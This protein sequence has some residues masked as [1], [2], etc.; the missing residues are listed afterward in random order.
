MLA[1]FPAAGQVGA[2]LPFIVQRT[3]IANNGFSML[4]KKNGEIADNPAI[5]TLEM[6][7]CIMGIGSYPAEEPAFQPGNF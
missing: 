5:L 6:P 2:L 1:E 3:R 7:E 4:P